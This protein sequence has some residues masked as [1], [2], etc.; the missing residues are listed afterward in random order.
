MGGDQ[1]TCVKDTWTKPKGMGSRVGIRVGWGKGCGK[2]KMETNVLEK[3]QQ[4]RVP[5]KM[6]V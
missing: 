5:A 4:K 2:L 1:G 3:Q 6:E